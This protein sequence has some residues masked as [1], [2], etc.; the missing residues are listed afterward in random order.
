[1]NSLSNQEEKYLVLDHGFVRVVDKMGD[2]SSIVQ[3]ARVSYGDGTKSTRDDER[4]IKYL[5]LNKHT[6]PFEM[7]EVKLH[8]KMPIFVARQW[9]RHR[10]ASINEVSARYSKMKDE[11]YFPNENNIQKQCSINKQGSNGVL[12]SEVAKW[13]INNLKRISDDCYSIYE[14]ALEKGISR[15]TAR[16]LLPVNLYTEFYW[17]IDLNNLLKFLMLRNHSHAQSEIRQYAD[18]IQ[19]KILPNWC[20]V[21]YSYLIEEV[22]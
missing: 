5:L 14:K 12:D 15:E 17:K 6:S 11:F 22:K 13:F 18:V 16:M 3:A 8:V 7:C 1:M 9:I 2:D 4:L 19:E 10:T 21:V 20:P